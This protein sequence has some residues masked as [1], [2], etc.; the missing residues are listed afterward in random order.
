MKCIN[1]SYIIFFLV[2]GHTVGNSCN[3][4]NKV[5]SGKYLYL[6]FLQWDTGIDL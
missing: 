5:R 1:Q 4:N 3:E 2:S 6:Q